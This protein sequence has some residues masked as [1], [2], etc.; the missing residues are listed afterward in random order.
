M[1]M[2]DNKAIKDIHFPLKVIKLP[3]IGNIWTQRN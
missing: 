2:H 1:L 3:Y